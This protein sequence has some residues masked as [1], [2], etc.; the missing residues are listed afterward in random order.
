MV[1]VLSQQ[2]RLATSSLAFFSVC[3]EKKWHQN[4]PFGR[5]LIFSQHT[6]RT[7]KEEKLPVLYQW[8]IS[9]KQSLTCGM[10][11][12]LMV[13]SCSLL[14]WIKADRGRF[15]HEN[16][17]AGPF[18][19]CG[20]LGRLRAPDPWQL[21]YAWRLQLCSHRRSSLPCRT[22]YLPTELSVLALAIHVKFYL[23]IYWEEMS[24]SSVHWSFYFLTWFGLV[25][26]RS[27][28]THPR[29]PKGY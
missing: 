24:K 20:K 9:N 6:R 12:V 27:D 1:S 14:S 13:L 3:P 21:V 25:L 4:W 8:E 17:Q 15:Y 23:W 7:E 19:I 28:R 18:L 2:H 22:Q 16:P 29:K 10:G 5:I 26:W 11:I